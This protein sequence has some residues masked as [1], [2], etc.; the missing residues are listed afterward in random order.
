MREMISSEFGAKRTT[1][2]MMASQTSWV[3]VRPIVAVMRSAEHRAEQ[4]EALLKA[5]AAKKGPAE[6]DHEE[7]QDSRDRTRGS[8]QPRS[9]QA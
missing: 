8:F 3:T 7:G 1:G 5:M 9:S 6:K 2:V 4:R